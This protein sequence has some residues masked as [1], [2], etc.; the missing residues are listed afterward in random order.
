MYQVGDR[1]VYGVHGVCCVVELQVQTVNRMKVEYYVLEPIKHSGSRYFVPSQNQIAVSKLRPLLTKEEL[2]AL[3]TSDRINEDIWI[4]NENDRRLQYREI[5]A[6]GDRCN[7]LRI[8]RTLR[9]HREEMLQSGKKFHVT[10][11]NFLKDAEKTLYSELSVVLNIEYDK[12]S[13]Y[14]NNL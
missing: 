11:A 12:V 1:V 4:A 2:D 3:L 14:I 10:D 9:K 7:L 8:I 6:E 5:I 13:D